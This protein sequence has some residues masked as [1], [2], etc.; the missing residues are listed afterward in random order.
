MRCLVTGCA[1][2]IGSHLTEALL[3]DGVS[4][5][6]ID[7]F[8]DNYGRDRKLQ[9][10]DH[11]RQW[12]S[13]EFI[14]LDLARGE[15]RD[16]VEEVDA[17]VHLAAEPGVRS[18]WGPRFDWY[19]RNNVV[20]TQQLLE[21]AR[22]FSE[23][24]LVY[25]SSSSVYGQA[26]AFPTPESAV[27]TPISPYG[28]TKLTAEHLCHTYHVN[29]GVDA[30]S[31]RF[32][33]VYGPRQRPDMAFDA[34]CRAAIE[35]RPIT[36]Y[37]DGLQSRDFTFVDDIVGGVRSALALPDIG[38]GVYNLG[39]GSQIGLRDAIAILSKVS[40]R[41]IDVHHLPR[42]HG[43][44]RDTGADISLAG[45]ELGYRPRTTLEHGLQQ[46]FEWVAAT[47]DDRLVGS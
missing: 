4:V 44:V 13:F 41:R 21:A 33:S 46:Q 14:P 19:L 25:A 27:P 42:E 29:H 24:R 20:A 16:V 17:I 35:G 23:K 2:F 22:D 43:D 9:N 6:G 30:V 26:E 40:G 1:G 15:L 37:G 5:L 39:G 7:C 34:F 12:E 8:N 32:F 31:L 10:L 18:S 11:A 28:V 36:V 3:A 45:A 38:G 47:Y